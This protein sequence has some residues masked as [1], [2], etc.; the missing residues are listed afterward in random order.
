MIKFHTI[1]INIFILAL[2]VSPLILRA[3]DTSLVF[4]NQAV[5]PATGEFIGTKCGW[6]E[7]VQLAQ[8]IINYLIL[9]AIPLAAVTFAWAGFTIMTSGGNSGKLEK[10]KEM[11]K[12]V[13]IGIFFVLAAW[14][15][16][17]LILTVLVG[18]SGDYSLLKKN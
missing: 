3:A 17:N 10:G 14:L 16:V 4:C 15:I 9:L 5:D 7:L 8:N 11:F 2:L 1:G 6:K 12:K 13:A 18:G